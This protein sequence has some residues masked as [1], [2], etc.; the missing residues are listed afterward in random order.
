MM[1]K[2]PSLYLRHLRGLS[3]LLLLA[4]TTPSA[5][6]NDFLP[7]DQAF[8]VSA[9]V[10]S[11]NQVQVSW[12]V[13]DG[14]YLYRDKFQFQSPMPGVTVGAPA[15]P[16]AELKQDQVFGQVAVYH[17]AGTLQLPI[18]YAA[19]AP[20]ALTLEVTTQGCADAGFCYPP[21]H[22]T[23]RLL[24]PPPSASRTAASDTARTVRQS[25]NLA[26]DDE[27][28]PV[29]EAFRLLAEVVAPDRVLLTW[30]IA[31]G[32]YLYRQT[33][34]IKLENSGETA[35][36]RVER[37]AGT[38]K[39]DAEL[40]DG[41]LGETEVYHDRL[42]LSVP[43][44]R[45][46][47]AATTATLVVSYQGCAEIGVCYPPQTQR[48][49]LQLPKAPA[50]AVLAP[51]LVAA[52][53]VNASAPQDQDH[54]AS[55]LAEGSL[56]AIVAIFFGFG[57]LLAFTPC[58]F[59]MIPILS[60]I[61]VGQGAAL[62]TR[63]AF[64]LS[65]MY[66]LAMALTYTL[67]GILAGLFGANLQATFQNPWIISAFALIFVLLALSM[68]GFYDLQLPSRLQSKLAAMS[69]HQQ[70]GTLFGVAIMGLLSALIVG[71][72]IAPPL[73]G[74]LIYISQTGDAVLGGL[75][76]LALS[77]G[78]G[79]P[80]VVIGT[81]AGRLLPRAGAWMEAIKAVFGVALLGVAM[82]LLERIVPPA[83]ALLLWGMLLIC[84][85]IYL[86]ALTQPPAGASGWR[87]LWKGVGVVLLIYGAL[88][89]IGAAAG[90]T[91]TLQPLRGLFAISGEASGQALAFQRIKTSPDL[92]R[93]LAVAKAAGKPVMLDF[94]A[95]WCVSCK[96][97]E[98]D[99]FSDPQVMAQLRDVVRLQADVT[100][101]DA[102]DQALMQD[103]FGIFGP[104]ALFFFDASG[105][106][107]A[108]M[109]MIGFVT[110]EELL[111]NLRRLAR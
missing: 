110:A 98:R 49:T 40:P 90:G 77:L 47:T 68:F 38:M 80:L 39:S 72:C 89:L 74:A 71:P 42:D 52:P 106:E 75:A 63:K 109:R 101:N 2:L 51:P 81:S 76:L 73:F 53:A 56:W 66:V 36:G 15:F 105:K 28:L 19:A 4:I 69:T 16:A 18:H 94:Y 102:L 12:R 55:V 104:P 46:S 65:L 60:G 61:I 107:L 32:T 87:I 93:A 33:L 31:P 41:T 30:D 62:T 21:Q 11:A 99:T 1:F 108:E 91:N 84:T 48:L 43:L 14:Y 8:Q 9:Q 29:T 83:L 20:D 92:E 95:D 6:Q 111:A 85:A 22:H 35:L 7:P 86:G 44:L 58:V 78:M 45:G 50:A 17:H 37:P 26:V 10:T 82:T 67:I 3:L 97:L 24:V 27:L 57:L 79:A 54:I 103:Q 64:L 96:E 23:L 100:A 34:D 59:P 25:L 5:A 70:G 88:L 13:A